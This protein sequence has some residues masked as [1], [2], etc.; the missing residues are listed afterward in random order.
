MLVAPIF[1]FLILYT[2]TTLVLNKVKKKTDQKG[3]RCTVPPGSIIANTQQAE[4]NVP[5]KHFSNR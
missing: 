1:V 2:Q 4:K 5:D 3:F